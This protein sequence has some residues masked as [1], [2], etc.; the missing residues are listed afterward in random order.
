MTE[1]QPFV[2][3]ALNTQGAA[4]QIASQLRAAIGAGVWSPGDRLPAEWQL[5]ETYG[6]SRGT[7]REALRL[8]TAIQLIKST[9]GAAGGT[10]V[11]VPRSDTV[12][13][14]IGDFIVL[15]LRAGDLAV[16]EVTHARRLLERECVR[17]A[18]S[19]RTEADLTAIGETID[20]VERGD[21]EDMEGWLAADIDFHTAVA[22]AAKNG[23]LE[24]AMT[25][26][27]LVRPRTNLLL[28]QGLERE[29]VWRQHLEI[30]EAVRDQDP[31]RAVRALEA[32]VD[33]LADVQHSTASD[34]ADAVPIAHLPR[35]G[36]GPRDASHAATHHRGSQP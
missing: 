2:P 3:Q 19:N 33:Y 25:A 4:S 16:G 26:V 31:E 11:V 30:F 6:V 14:Q 18:A 7:V 32:H 36:P 12:A 8:L 20:R 1:S 29:P 35:E 27:H 21:P 10:F 28:L 5:A 17:L 9:R 24:L 22:A 13:E 15:R 23:I 34:N